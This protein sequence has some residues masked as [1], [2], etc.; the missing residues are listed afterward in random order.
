MYTCSKCGSP[1]NTFYTCIKCGKDNSPHGTQWDSGSSPDT[2]G[3]YDRCS[4]CGARAR[5]VDDRTIFFRV[6]CT[7][8]PET[9]NPCI[10]KS[11]AQIQWNKVQRNKGV[12]WTADSGATLSPEDRI[13]A[14]LHN[15][16]AASSDKETG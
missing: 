3:L 12:E 15:A 6:E 1:L 2:D 11:M 4:R 13:Q 5:M 7:E 8:C 14:E 9:T 16:S 10:C